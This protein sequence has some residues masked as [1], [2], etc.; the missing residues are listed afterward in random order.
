MPKYLVHAVSLFRNTYLVEADNP[1]Y[2]KD[3]V[4]CNVDTPEIDQEWIGETISNVQEI[5]KKQLKVFFDTAVN[6]HIAD[7]L[8]LRQPD[9]ATKA[10]TKRKK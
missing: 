7:E 9:L 2:A 3:L 1:E 10:L 5:D 4:T 8:T 6:G